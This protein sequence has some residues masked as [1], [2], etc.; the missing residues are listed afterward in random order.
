ML[1]KRQRLSKTFQK[2]FLSPACVNEIK[3]Y[4]TAI[5][6]DAAYDTVLGY[7]PTGIYRD[8]QTKRRPLNEGLGAAKNLDI[9]VQIEN[10]IFLCRV[11]DNT[12]PNKSIV[13]S[14]L[15]NNN[16]DI[17]SNFNLADWISGTVTGTLENPEPVIPN[18]TNAPNQFWAKPNYRPYLQ[19][20]QEKMSSPEYKKKIKNI[21]LKYVQINLPVIK[22]QLD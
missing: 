10:D 1:A 17:L 19:T 6:F 18:I 22:N 2:I 13:P 20:L 15:K 3:R 8:P 7:P 21:L 4:L 12:P 9:T 14:W 16:W 11:T 5:T